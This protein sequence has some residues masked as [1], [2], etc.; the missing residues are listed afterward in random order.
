VLTYISDTTAIKQSKRR[1]VAY[2]ALEEEDNGMDID[3]DYSSQ[4]DFLMDTP[5]SPSSNP[6][7][8]NIIAKRLITTTSMSSLCSI[9]LL[10]LLILT[11][12]STTTR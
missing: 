8:E 10:H 5:T 3:N 4:E 7:K 11:L 1:M 12:S 6:A 9:H 2:M